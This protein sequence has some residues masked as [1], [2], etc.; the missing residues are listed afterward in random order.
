MITVQTEPFALVDSVLYF[1]DLKWKKKICV[2]APTHL[3]NNL[4]QNM[5]I[6]FF[7]GHFSRNWL[8]T[9]LSWS[10]WW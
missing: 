3:W 5:N 7:A 4:M 10:W 6:A 8:F 1:V 2:R 9:S